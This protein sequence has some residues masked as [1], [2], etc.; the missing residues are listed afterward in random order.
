MD[1]KLRVPQTKVEIAQQIVEGNNNLLTIIGRDIFQELLHN[2]NVIDHPEK[3]TQ[4]ISQLCG[5]P[6]NNQQV[7]TDIRK[8]P[9]TGNPDNLDRDLQEA[10][11][12]IRAHNPLS[13]FR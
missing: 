2:P 9:F 11:H 5:D 4:L 13:I 3:V 8:H 1:E 12:D 7:Y 6:L 10:D